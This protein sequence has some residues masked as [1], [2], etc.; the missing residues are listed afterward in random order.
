[1]VG[2]AVIAFVA[3]AWWGWNRPLATTGPIRSIAVLP[4]ENL[5]GDSEQEYFVDGM[6]ESLDLGALEDQRAARH[7]AN[8]DHGVP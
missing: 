2:R 7:L 4:L 3:L 5:S 1:M 8:L 6:T